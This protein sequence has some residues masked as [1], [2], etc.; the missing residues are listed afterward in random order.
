MFPGGSL[1]VRKTGT[2]GCRKKHGHPKADS[3]L[4]RGMVLYVAH[5]DSK[6]SLG[7]N[8]GFLT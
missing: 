1:D 6:P 7:S 2:P 8:S 5:L 4:L 3:P